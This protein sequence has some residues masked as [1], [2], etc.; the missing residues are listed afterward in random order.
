MYK[1]KRSRI[2]AVVSAVLILGILYFIEKREALP[3]ERLV[4]S[5][6]FEY[7]KEPGTES[8]HT[9]ESAEI[10]VYIC[11]SVKNPGVY[12]ASEGARIYEV[13]E[14]A[15]GF[16]EDADKTAV[17]LAETV[18]D[19][20]AVLIPSV[21]DVQESGVSASL[22]DGRVNI[23]TAGLEDLMTLPGIGKAKAEAVIAYRNEHGRFTSIEGL[24]EVSGIGEGVFNKL[25]DR[26]KI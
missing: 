26:I 6:S 13:L 22:S 3:E 15:G 1:K 12:S 2:L 14:M 16:S 25:R 10:C 8:L 19:G 4:V 24:M 18:C 7:G 9:E 5:D 21:S 17:N 23:N 11:G 20:E